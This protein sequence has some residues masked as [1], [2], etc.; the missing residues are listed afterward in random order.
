ME[1][2]SYGAASVF[3]E[4][5]T[6]AKQLEI[7]NDGEFPCVSPVDDGKPAVTTSIHGLF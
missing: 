4:P 5:K 2:S 3:D 7:P 6:T 1:V